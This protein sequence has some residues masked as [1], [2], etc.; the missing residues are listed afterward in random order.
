MNIK[1]KLFICGEERELLTTNLNYN[2]LTDWN[3][4]PTS[5]LLGGTISVTFESEMYDDTFV[6]WIK[7]DRR[8]NKKIR[9]PFN[10]YQLR[11]GKIVFYKD[12][13]DGVELFQYN[14]QDSVLVNYYETFDNQKGMQ[15]T[16]T[17]STAMQDYRFF[18]NST[19]WRRKSP[20]RYI[21][22]W[23]ESYIP[24]IKETSYKAQENKEPKKEKYFIE[25]IEIENLDEGSSNGGANK[26]EGLIHGKEYILKVTKYKNDKVPKNSNTIKWSYDYTNA[27]GEI[28]EGSINAK[29]DKATFK[30][31]DLDYCGN[32]ITFYAYIESKENEAELEVFHHYRFRWFDRKR[33][34]TQAQDRKVRPWRIDQGGTSLCGMACIFYLLAKKDPKGY[35]NL[36]EELHRIGETTYNKYVVSPNSDSYK[37]YDVKPLSND[38]PNI[39]DVDWITMA[40]TRNKESSFGYTGKINQDASAINWPSI[41][42]KLSEKLLACN[43]VSTEGVYSSVIARRISIK[44]TEQKVDDINKQIN[45]GYKLM[46]MIDSDL[47]SDDGDTLF[48]SYQEFH[49]VV[50]EKTIRKIQ[51]W[52]SKGRIINNYDFKVYSWGSDSR[53]LKTQIT[54][55]HFAKNYY[56]YIKVK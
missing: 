27:K 35:Y 43:D 53:Y 15:V 25:K 39:P 37:L 20:T 23:Q 19:D 54:W 33:V 45:K 5:A 52:D 42:T 9:H 55:E 38:H 17:I 13:F 2:R 7:S 8:G 56:G 10:L 46:L 3:G 16:L 41:M 48:S 14:F 1:A 28:V 32:K 47:I 30:A 4:K 40:V 49:W 34:L 21:K 29:G 36:V 51:A 24:P 18:N 11:D 50:L 22:H 31:N 44:I 12:E 26:K 6:D